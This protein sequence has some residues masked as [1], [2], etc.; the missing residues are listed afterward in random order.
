MSRKESVQFNE[1]GYWSRTRSLSLSLLFVMPLL[2]IYE[3][4]LLVLQPGS[5]NAVGAMVRVLFHWLDSGMAVFNVVVLLTLAV[6]WSRSQKQGG[7]QPG[8]LVFVCIESVFWGACMTIFG[9]VFVALGKSLPMSMGF[10]GLAA[11]PHAPHGY[12]PAVWHAATSIV[13]SCGA[14]VYEELLFRLLLVTFFVW[15]FGKLLGRESGDESRTPF[16]AIFMGLMVSALLFA[17][18]HHIPPQDPPAMDAVIFRTV[19]GFF[20][21]VVFLV[22]GLAVA[23]YTHTLFDVYVLIVHAHLVPA[24]S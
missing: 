16:T 5:Q 9:V 3:V 1:G 13:Q 10:M 17:L 4:G 11:A 2:V 12:D 15:I 20:L 7:I 21:G 8:Y 24:A 22:R 14:G 23:V 19:C 18:A 6:A